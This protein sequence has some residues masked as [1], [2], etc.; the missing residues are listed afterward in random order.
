MGRSS[1][2]RAPRKGAATVI[3]GLMA[4]LIAGAIVVSGSARADEPVSV[5]VSSVSGRTV[6]LVARLAPGIDV[7][8]GVQVSSQV[9]IAGEQVPTTSSV[10]VPDA[11]RTVAIL[12]LDASGSMRGERLAAAKQAAFS[13]VGDLPATVEVGLI[14]F[15]QQVRAAAAPGDSRPAVLGAIDETRAGGDTSLYD[16]VFAAAGQVPANADARLIVLSDGQDTASSVQLTD[17]VRAAKEAGVPVDVVALAPTAEERRI[18]E[19]LASPTGGRVIQASTIA[20]LLPAFGQAAQPFGAR[21]LLESTI[22][23]AI[24]ASGGEVDVTITI[25]GRVFSGQTMLP[26]APGLGA[27]PVVVASSAPE[28]AAVVIPEGFNWP[29]ALAIAA[30]ILVLALAWVIV[31]SVERSRRQK[32][33]DQ[34]GSYQSGLAGPSVAPEVAGPFALLDGVLE[35]TDYERRQRAVLGG[36]EIPL[37]PGGWII[38]RVM[39]CIIIGILGFL[40]LNSMLGA[41]VGIAIAWLASMSWIRSR[42]ARRQRSFGDTLPDFLMLL[43]S[44]LRAG[45]SFNHALE[46][47]AGEDKGEVGRQIRRALR[48]VQIG[49]QLDDALMDCAERMDNEDLRWTVTALSIQ[50]E[51]GGNLSTI[52]ETASATIKSRDEL[53]REV[54]TLSAEG[55]LSGY[56]LIGLPLGVLAF[57][58]VIRRDYVELLWTTSLGL[59]M[60]GVMG[61]LMVV[62][63]FWMRAIVRIKV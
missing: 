19:K 5:E 35:G 45:L 11:R 30:G 39:V 53:R 13:F 20:E 15:D 22:P 24:D 14:T 60:L 16:A 55:R 59:L 29:I 42:R 47:A 6:D 48:E 36:A 3:A 8:P 50:R 32:R 25:D 21:V 4:G 1:S 51:V 26:V 46:S 10:D 54:R 40:I 17:A 7:P 57:L 63:W 61:V 18:L 44:G 41:V 27:V 31:S 62:G 52:L 37:S 9:E 23:D 56:I 12:V 38:A 2:L 43:A 49:A 34:V 33:L 28:A 58:I